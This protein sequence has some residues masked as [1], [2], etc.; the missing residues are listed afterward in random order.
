MPPPCDWVPA[1]TST[2]GTNFPP[3]PSVERGQLNLATI[4]RYL[5]DHSVINV[6]FRLLF[7]G[8]KTLV[9]LPLGTKTIFGSG[10]LPIVLLSHGSQR[11][12]SNYNLAR[13]LSAS[14]TKNITVE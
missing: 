13:F 12:L 11:E 9:L 3:G 14:Q 7:P 10:A 5:V 1:Q 4:R 2:R 6:I 8:Y